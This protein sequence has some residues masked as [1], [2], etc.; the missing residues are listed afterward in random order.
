[1]ARRL[2]KPRSAFARRALATEIQRVRREERE[3]RH[4]E[5]YRRNPVSK[6]EFGCWIAEQSRPD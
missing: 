4:R 1:M 3:R 5:G 2:G 6:T